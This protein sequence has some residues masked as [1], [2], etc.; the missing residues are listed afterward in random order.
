MIKP[1]GAY[2]GKEQA[3][4]ISAV[5]V[6]RMIAAS[7]GFEPESIMHVPNGGHRGYVTGAQLKAGGVVPGYPDIMVFLTEVLPPINRR[8]ETLIPRC[9]LALELKIWPRR[10]T[11]EQEHVH[12]ILRRAGW[13][14][15]TCWSL[16]QVTSAMSRH[17]GRE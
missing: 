10:P 15:E 14:V 11:P 4:Q 1:P 9:G 17:I 12:E 8:K 2:V 7:S 3:F 16:D 13:R 6:L 5:K